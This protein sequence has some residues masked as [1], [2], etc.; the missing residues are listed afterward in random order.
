MIAVAVEMDIQWTDTDACLHLRC[1]CGVEV[2]SDAPYIERITCDQ[3]G[4]TYVFPR[5]VFVE[6]R[7]GG[8]V[9]VS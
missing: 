1:L 8:D 2:H 9:P 6:V 5:V 7:D 3:C 4:R